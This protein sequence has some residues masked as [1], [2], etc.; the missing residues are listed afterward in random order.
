MLAHPKYIKKKDWYERE[1]GGQ[2]KTFSS[3]KK[4]KTRH[5]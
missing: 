1:K 4:S 3:K 2:A 5:I